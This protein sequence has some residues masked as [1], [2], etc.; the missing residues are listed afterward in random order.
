LSASEATKKLI[1]RYY[2]DLL[3]KKEWVELL[4]DDFLLTGTVA[5]ESIGRD[6]YIANGFFKLVRGHKVKEVV[7]EGERGFALVNYDLVSPTGKTMS[8]DVAE[9][10][11]AGHGR[12]LS[13]SIYFD[14]TAFNRFLSP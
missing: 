8:C 5:K 3:A 14:T 2:L 11:K 9:F 10:W 6:Q 4:A 1:E 12:L 7:V 13:V